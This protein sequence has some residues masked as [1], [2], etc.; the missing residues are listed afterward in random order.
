M[1]DAK[2]GQKSE[3]GT[4]NF[5]SYL[6]TLAQLRKTDENDFKLDRST[7][8][9]NTG[10]LYRRARAKFFTTSVILRL[11]ELDSPLKKAYWN[12]YYCCKTLTK[13]HATEGNN[14]T[15]T[16]KYCKNRWCMVC[17]RIRTAELMNKYFELTGTWDDKQFVTLTIP[18]VP[19][20]D[21]SLAIDNMLIDF[22]RIQE[23]MRKR[24]TPIIGI[25]KLECTY[26]PI[27]DDYHP[28]FHVIIRGSDSAKELLLQWLERNPTASNL[29][30]DVRPANNDDLKEL[31]K[32]FTKIISGKR[33]NG[34][35][36]IV[37][38]S[39]DVIFNAVLGRRTFQAFG[40]IM[41]K[42]ETPPSDETKLQADLFARESVYE[43][44]DDLQDWIDTDNGEM[45]TSYKPTEA[46]KKLL[47]S[48]E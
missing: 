31:F 36:K 30:Q 42:V 16:G 33:L 23:V 1:F 26:N 11:V 18:N 12:T 9:K 45:L 15:I 40:F 8:A 38:R 3:I 4:T 22:K 19:A 46:F 21:L 17:S 47:G 43:W 6:D 27:R 20:S 7:E 24:K 32:Y 44:I 39:L 28:H 2:I 5:S 41:P 48:I 34:E 25:R 37:A 35:R 13:H 14:D 29:G 10:I